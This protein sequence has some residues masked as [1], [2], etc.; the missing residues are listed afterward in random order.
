MKGP[1]MSNYSIALLTSH[2]DQGPVYTVRY[3]VRGNHVP[4]SVDFC[5]WESAIGFARRMMALSLDNIAFCK[6]SDGYYAHN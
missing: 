1:Q 6:R 3:H 2:D 4:T 5:D